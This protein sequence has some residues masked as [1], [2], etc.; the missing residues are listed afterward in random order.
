MLGFAYTLMHRSAKLRAADANA[1]CGWTRVSG[2]TASADAATGKPI[3]H[4][5]IK[6]RLMTA[7]TAR[8]IVNLTLV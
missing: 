6:N 4:A 7:R 8:L 5:A 1:V 3:T 2:Q